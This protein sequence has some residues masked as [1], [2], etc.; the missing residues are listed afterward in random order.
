MLN[1]LRSMVSPTYKRPSHSFL[2]SYNPYPLNRLQLSSTPHSRTDP[3]EPS[4]SLDAP[5]TPT[6][7]PT[8]NTVELPSSGT[9]SEWKFKF[10]YLLPPLA[11]VGCFFYFK[12]KAKKEAT[13]DMHEGLISAKVLELVEILRRTDISAATMSKVHEEASKIF[14]EGIQADSFGEFMV[15][16][17]ESKTLYSTDIHALLRT[18]TILNY[19]VALKDCLVASSM[20]IATTEPSERV[21]LAWNVIDSDSDQ[22]LHFEEFVDLLDRMIRT[23]HFN[24]Q[25]LLRLTS[26]TPPE[27]QILSPLGL[28]QVFYQNL[29]KSEEEVISWQEFSE[30][31]SSAEWDKSKYLWYYDGTLLNIG[32]E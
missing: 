6:E 25:T 1:M 19:G 31:M 3:V 12:W 29:K 23:G 2:R 5:S 22:L 15:N 7:P 4:P 28:A 16:V 27:Y 21:Q 24:G 8:S 10:R 32:K 18:A 30:L 17:S 14:A 9:K 20:L 13:R 26:W 11:A